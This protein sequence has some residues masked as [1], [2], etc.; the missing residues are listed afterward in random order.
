MLAGHPLAGLGRRLLAAAAGLAIAAATHAYP[1]RVVLMTHI[2]DNTPAG[3]LGTVTARNSYLAQRGSL[4][5]MG[6]LCDSLGVKWTL[7]PD[8]KILEAA[9]IYE[10]ATVT[11]STGGKNVFRFLAEDLAVTID[12]HSH[13]NGGYN[14]TDVAHLLD[15]LGVGGSTVI[16][17]H[18][19]DP[20][21]PQFQEWDRFR[22]PVAG[23][24]YPGAHWRGDILIG[25][26]TPN[27][28]NDPRVSGVWHP[29]DR[30]HYFTYAPDSNIVAVGTYG[31]LMA[32]AEE[33]IG[34]YRNGIVR[35]DRML[36]FHT[37]LKP[38]AIN[39]VAARAALVDTVLAPMLAWQDSGWVELTDF[40]TLVADWAA[41]YRAV[42]WLYDGGG[43][44]TS[45]SPA[46]IQAL[47]PAAPN[48]VREQTALAFT[49]P[50]AARVRLA[51]HD[52]QGREIARLADGPHGPGTHGA[53]W[54]ARGQ[55]A[56]V[57]FA[58]LTVAGEPGARVRKLLVIR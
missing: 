4:L 54:D 27:H 42:D 40:A 2:E 26:G 17:G 15:S 57:Y 56:G 35:H 28:V 8:Y 44:I 58:R 37:N 6:R 53:R 9:L 10:D 1:V 12:P 13:E 36:T 20:S 45:V 30:D 22:V 25:A 18:I 21:L 47:A 29:Q 51:I 55:P 52:L 3:V 24:H 49:L 34:L 5:A 16:G 33:L 32:D 46:G 48:P 43:T 7:Q 50:A 41:D 14:Y 31:G 11:G 39:S 23:Q 38:L 19:W